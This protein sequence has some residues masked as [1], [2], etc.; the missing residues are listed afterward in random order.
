MNSS[1]GPEW[2][3]QTLALADSFRLADELAGDEG[4]ASE[5][6][7]DR[8]WAALRAHLECKEREHLATKAL[9]KQLAEA[10][11]VAFDQTCSV[12]RPKD[13]EQLRAALAAYQEKT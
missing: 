10:C 4:E 8:T 13:W 3:E 2:V 9:V 7:A 5:S 1:Q 6:D 11:K 12:G